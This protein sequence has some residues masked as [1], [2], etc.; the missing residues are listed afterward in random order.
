MSD[1]ARPLIVTARF[2]SATFVQ[3]DALRR[4]H[5][6]PARN[7]IPA[8]L[9]LF[10]ALPGER[11]SEVRDMLRALTVQQG[12]CALDFTALRSLGRGVAFDVQAP[13][14][15]AL[16]QR[17]ARSFQDALTPQDAGGFRPHVTIQNK[18]SPDDARALLDKLRAAFA[19]WSGKATGLLMWRYLGGPW[20]LEGEF[21]FG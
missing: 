11:A 14:L 1:D 19:P 3:L 10:H 12:A 20:A 13:A 16:R 15:V 5:F 4:A 9:T 7:F 18:V 8:H 2:D 6:P 17:L 21:P